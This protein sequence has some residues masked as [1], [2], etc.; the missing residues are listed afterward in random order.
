MIAPLLVYGSLCY[1]L[2]K[3]KVGMLVNVQKRIVKWISPIGGSYEACLK[4]L[5]ILP[6]PMYIQVNNLLILSKLILGRY[7]NELNDMPFYTDSARCNLFQTQ[8]PRKR[9]LE[10]IF[11]YQTCRLANFVKIDLRQKNGLKKLILRVFWRRVE[12][13]HVESWL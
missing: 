9:I 10:E 1:G 6:L 13:M 11:F 3:N 8:R 5:G 12:Q 7:D 2:S 4:F